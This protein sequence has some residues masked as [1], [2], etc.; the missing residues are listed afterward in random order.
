MTTVTLEEAQARLPELIQ[1]L[2][3]GEELVITNHAQ[4]VARLVGGSPANG[5]GRR[6][7]SAKGM[8]VVRSEDEAHLDDFEER[9]R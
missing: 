3:P 5:L 1:G 9:L 4:A 6:P 2:G 8:L 7:G